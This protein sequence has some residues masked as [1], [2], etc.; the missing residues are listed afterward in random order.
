MGVIELD[1]TGCSDPKPW[2]LSRG[3]L[4]VKTIGHVPVMV[5]MGDD[6]DYIRRVLLYSYYYC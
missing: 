3:I 6:E 4:G 2:G 1:I 5:A